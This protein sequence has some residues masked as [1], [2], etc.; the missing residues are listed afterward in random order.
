MGTIVEFK[1]RI[2]T[3]KVSAVTT[4]KDSYVVGMYE[5]Y[6]NSG[7]DILSS[8]IDS[9]FKDLFDALKID[10][11]LNTLKGVVANNI[12][13]YSTVLIDYIMSERI[14]ILPLEYEVG[15]MVVVEFVDGT[16]NMMTLIL[17]VLVTSRGYTVLTHF[18]KEIANISN[19]KH[20]NIQKMDDNNIDMWISQVNNLVKYGMIYK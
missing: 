2:N 17:G 5:K 7:K 18:N 8:F 10:I 12:E 3:N 11:K 1:K 13:E 6:K 9:K 15:D 14:R 4:N 19:L 16:P 20:D